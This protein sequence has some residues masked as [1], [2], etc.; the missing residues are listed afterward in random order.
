[1][2]QIIG[3]LLGTAVGDAIGLPYEGLSRRRALK[4]LGKP[5][6]HRL[7]LGI[8][9]AAVG[10]EGIPA[11]WRSGLIEWPRSLDW[12]ERLGRQLEQGTVGRSMELSFFSLLLRNVGFLAIV[13]FHGFRRLLPF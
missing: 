8:V 6:K 11:S 2:G 12:M 3:S 9:G 13:I 7:F 4:L 1:M 10:V 5:T